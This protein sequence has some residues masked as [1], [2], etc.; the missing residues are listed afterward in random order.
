MTKTRVLFLCTHNSARSQ[1]AEGL[2]RHIG[3]DKFEVESAGTEK[4][5]VQ[6]LAME[7]MQEIGVDISRHTSKTLDQFRSQAW[8]YVITVCARA[9]ESCPTFPGDTKRIHWGFDDP[10]AAAGSHDEKVRV[11]RR[12][13]DEL[14]GRL[15]QFAVIAERE[16]PDQ[17]HREK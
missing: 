8:D 15:R 11:Y 16:R 12:V 14:V 7:A 3:G 1:M 9:N 4:T 17:L 13:R 6:P 2:L 10:S 5:Q